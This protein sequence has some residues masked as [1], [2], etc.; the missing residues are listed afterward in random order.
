MIALDLI[1]ISIGGLATRFIIL[2]KLHDE[3]IELEENIVYVSVIDLLENVIQMKLHVMNHVKN[4]NQLIIIID[5]KD[6]MIDISLIMA[7]VGKIVSLE[8][9]L[10]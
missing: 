4:L 3:K 5:L 6:V 8:I 10:K 9:E 2:M 7:Y 1:M